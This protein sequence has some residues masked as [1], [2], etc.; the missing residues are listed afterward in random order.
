MTGECWDRIDKENCEV[1]K[2][3]VSF[4]ISKRNNSVTNGNKAEYTTFI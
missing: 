2:I 1:K 4:D 3:E